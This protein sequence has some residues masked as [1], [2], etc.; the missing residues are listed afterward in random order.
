MR[1]WHFGSGDVSRVRQA[2]EEAEDKLA[3]LGEPVE[4]VE[5]EGVLWRRRSNG[6][7]DL[8]P[9]CINCRV[10]L[11]E[12]GSMLICRKCNWDAPLPASQISRVRDSLP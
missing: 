3:K 8:S 5:A 11:S 2:K 12:C 6:S 1:Y 4:F 9:C 7:Y 10:P